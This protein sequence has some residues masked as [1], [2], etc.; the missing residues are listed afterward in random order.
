[1]KEITSKLHH[2]VIVCR[3]QEEA[4]QAKLPVNNAEV[5]VTTGPEGQWLDHKLLQ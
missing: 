2:A 5:D 4:F 1:M 3:I